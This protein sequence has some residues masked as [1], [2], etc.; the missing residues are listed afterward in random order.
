[1]NRRGFT[2][3]ELLV[4]IAIIALLAGI[5][6]P[7][8]S[9]SREKARQ[10]TCQSNLKQIGMALQMYSQDYSDLFPRWQVAG[11]AG[12]DRMWA[13]RLAPYA[14]IK[15]KYNSLKRP[16]YEGTIF[17]CPS[18]TEYAYGVPTDYMYY[19]VLYGYNSCLDNDLSMIAKPS[20]V[21][22]V[23]D[24]EAFTEGTYLNT[25]IGALGIADIGSPLRNRHAGGLNILYCDGHVKWYRAEKG[26]NLT[27][28][29][30]AKKHE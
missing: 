14:G 23:A 28:I 4:V 17:D 8:F 5:L 13:D 7:V 15:G 9:Q 1:M 26:A 3:I 30:N 6:F 19:A 21:G 22:I 10:A 18:M 16:G 2:L 25:K 20:E 24:S 27:E 12:V 11:T 29:F